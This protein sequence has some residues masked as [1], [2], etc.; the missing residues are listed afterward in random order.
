[1]AGDMY[2]DSASQLS[3]S[4]AVSLN[5]IRGSVDLVMPRRPDTPL[6]L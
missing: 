4:S 5:G 2:A 3:G 6:A 1:M